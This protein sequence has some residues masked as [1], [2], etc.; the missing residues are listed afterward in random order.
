[1]LSHWISFFSKL[2]VLGFK[3]SGGG[4]GSSSTYYANADRLYGEQAELARITREWAEANIP[5]AID[6]FSRAT[7]RYFDPTYEQQMV[8]QAR[9]DAQNAFADQKASLTR[10]MA[11]YGINP[12]SG[13][14]GSMANQSAI[15]GAQMTAGAAN[16]ARQNVQD[17]QFGASKDFYSTLSG[18]PSDSAKASGS[19]ASGFAQM[20]ANKEASNNQASAGW[21]QFGGAL[22]GLAFRDGGE[23]RMANGGL[24]KG[25][26]LY[27]EFDQQMPA[28]PQVQ[29]Q[30]TP[31]PMQGAAQGI[32]VGG[33][34]KDVYEGKKAGALS[35]KIGGIAEG[36][37]NLFGDAG[38]SAWGLGAQGAAA[39]TDMTA[40]I[41]AYGEA[42]TAAKAAGDLTA[43]AE[44]ATVAEGLT[45]G[46]AAAGTGGTMAAVS[47][48][49][50]WV[51]AAA[52]VGSLFGLF[53]DGGEVTDV[54][55]DI[56]EAAKANVYEALF[57][58][59]YTG[60]PEQIVK[61][62]QLVRELMEQ[63]DDGRI[64]DPTGGE[65]DGPGT[66]TSD[67]IPARLSDGEFVVNADAVKLPG[68]RE[69]LHRINQAGLERR[70]SR[71]GE[72]KDEP[73]GNPSVP[74]YLWDKLTGKQKDP[75]QDAADR[76]AATRSLAG[77]GVIGGTGDTMRNSM[78]R[79]AREAER[80]ARGYK[81]GG[82]VKKGK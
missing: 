57:A 22:L 20:G 14:W 42:A 2:F 70:Y 69:Q 80:Q 74:Q 47:A 29:P 77:S 27:P 67:S 43:A 61:V 37:G 65:V 26:G 39:G 38:T 15:Q 54:E 55:P 60:A 48:A 36:A 13:K 51:A 44:F 32:K 59:P 11:R 62:Q 10:D 81:C 1:M 21:G 35:S 17:K 56:Q 7:S 71:G 4:G 3:S 82:L 75:A 76:K 45:A 41:G 50:P 63:G 66:E 5:G 16:L 24:L 40:A 30:G 78:D 53:A 6:Q 8:G 31:T 23:V 72:V 68:V 64:E 28:Q 46:T 12:A 73:V 49:V 18:L 52:A 33:A 79:K 19:A 58:E 34:L 9:I 25:R